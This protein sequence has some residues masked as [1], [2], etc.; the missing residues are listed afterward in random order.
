[1]QIKNCDNPNLKIPSLDYQT[2][3]DKLNGEFLFSRLVY[4]SLQKD[5]PNFILPLSFEFSL[6]IYTCCAD[7]N[8]KK[9]IFDSS[10]STP[11]L[12][13]DLKSSRIPD[14]LE[15]YQLNLLQVI[16]QFNSG[17]ILLRRVLKCKRRNII[18]QSLE[19]TELYILD[20]HAADE[21]FNYSQL[22]RNLTVKSQ[23][24][25]THVHLNLS[26]IEEDLLLQNAE[27]I[28]SNGFH[29]ARPNKQSEQ[30][31]IFAVP[32]IDGTILYTQDLR[33]LLISLQDN[34]EKKSFRT[35]SKGDLR[36]SRY[37]SIIASRA[38]RAS[39]MFGLPLVK[40]QMEQILRNISLNFDPWS[41]PHGRPTI[42]Y[43]YSAF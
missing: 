41:C 25:S 4:Q 7:R 35:T 29:I 38:C 5:Q 15:K 42:Q 14:K 28:R 36:P 37:F 20:Q 21:R 34:N 11:F 19:K 12:F 18:H 43:L 6:S 27:V 39:I 32:N 33:E 23:Y 8:L 10:Y 2:E 17:F 3:D 22:E 9:T 30:Y 26:I 16:G 31:R 13:T 40:T 1:M 24:L